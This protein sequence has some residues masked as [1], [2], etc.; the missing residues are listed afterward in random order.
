MNEESYRVGYDDGYEDALLRDI[1]AKLHRISLRENK[2]PK[3]IAIEALKLYIAD[4]QREKR[5]KSVQ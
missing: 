1:G 5:K 4:L 3:E 2:S